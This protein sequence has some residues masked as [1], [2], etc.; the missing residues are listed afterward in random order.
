MMNRAALIGM[1]DILAGATQP[2]FEVTVKL[3]KVAFTPGDTVVIADLT[4]A[5]YTGYAAQ[6]AAEVGVAWDDN[7]GNAVI[8]Y[9]GLHFQ[10]TGSAITNTI[11]GWVATPGITIGGGT[12]IVAM[13]LFDPP[14]AMEKVADAIDFAPLFKLG[15]PHEEE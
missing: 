8:S 3:I 13:G 7:A 12:P 2:L 6:V 10:P 14:R 11:Y 15:Q 4:E 9:E 1:A 5:D